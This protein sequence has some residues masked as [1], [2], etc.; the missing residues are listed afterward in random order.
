MTILQYPP[1]L[2]ITTTAEVIAMRLRGG[3]YAVFHPL[4]RFAGEV[5][6]ARQTAPSPPLRPLRR[7]NDYEIPGNLL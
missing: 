1:R 7:G 4:S 6:S 3:R 5:A 2:P